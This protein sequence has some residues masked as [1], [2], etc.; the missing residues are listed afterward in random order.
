MKATIIRPTPKSS[1]SPQ[2]GAASNPPDA[3]ATAAS[4]LPAPDSISALHHLLIGPLAHSGESIDITHQVIGL[5]AQELWKR[6]RETNDVLNWIE[7]ERLFHDAMSRR[8]GAV[9]IDAATAPPAGR[10]SRRHGREHV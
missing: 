1:T 4:P 5:I 10:R 8:N 9:S 7:A 3:L 6:D 2:V